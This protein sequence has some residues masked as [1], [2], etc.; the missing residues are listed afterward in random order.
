MCSII[1]CL[2]HAL[3][4]TRYNTFQN[5][6]SHT[7]FLFS[8]S[9]LQPACLYK[10]VSCRQTPLTCC[11][12]LP[13]ATLTISKSNWEKF[14]LAF[15]F[16]FL[17]TTFREAVVMV[18]GYKDSSSSQCT[19]V[20]RALRLGLWMCTNECGCVSCIK[21]R[22]MPWRGSGMICQW[23]AGSDVCFIAC[24]TEDRQKAWIM[25]YLLW[26]RSYILLP[27]AVFLSGLHTKKD[28]H[29]FIFHVISTCWRLT[30]N[31]ENN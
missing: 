31:S 23:S 17:F 24:W 21:P 6:T 10:P 3:K 15:P 11:E 19:R 14:T 9:H 28:A 1:Y 25:I 26:W 16:F 30:K 27:F 8:P 5:F 12:Q 29:F 20:G 4:V 7:S 13:T 2:S 22:I 18:M